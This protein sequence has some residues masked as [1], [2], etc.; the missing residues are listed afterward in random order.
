VRQEPGVDIAGDAG[1]VVGQC[2]GRTAHD[3]HVGDDAPA[4][5][6]LTQGGE[7]PFEVRPAE[8]DVVGFTH[9]ASRSRADR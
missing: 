9:A 1:G 7:S 3:E 6:A 2:H 4:G 8:E 5:Q